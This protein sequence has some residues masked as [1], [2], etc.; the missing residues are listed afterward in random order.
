MR[1]VIQRVSKA[2]VS[3]A[4]EIV[5]EIERGAVILLGIEEADN[6]EDIAWLTRKIA[7]T[8]IFADSEGLMNVSLEEINGG[9]LVISQFTLH[10]N[11]K[12]GNRPSFTRAARP[13]HALPLYE[14]FLKQLSGQLP[15]PCQS[16]VFGADMQVNLVNDGPVTLII[17]SKNRE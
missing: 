17:D 5:G 3:I 16:G 13:E 15:H 9:A 7:K 2:A 11:T 10:A 4:G 14:D 6:M 12:K 8:R 1:V